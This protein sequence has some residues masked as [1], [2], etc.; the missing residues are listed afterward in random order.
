MSTRAAAAPPLPPAKADY[1]I[2][3][4]KVVRHMLRR[5]ALI[6]LLGAAIWFMNRSSAAGPGFALFCVLAVIGLGFVAAALFMRWS[7]QVGKVRV[8]DQILETLPWRGDEK[9]LDAGCGRGLFLIGAAKRLAKPAKATGVDIWSTED[10]AGNSAEAAMANARAEGV[11]D[12]V[13]IETG[14]LRK[15]PYGSSVFDTVVSSLAIHNLDEPD[16]REKAVREMWR[17]L[18]SGGHLAVFDVAHTA[19]YLNVLKPAG[20]E[21]LRESG[22]S[23]LWMIP[24][25]RWFIV[26]KPSV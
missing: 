14:D 3:A 25:T 18:K 12:R 19:D 13:K 5:G 21:L 11:A 10:L 20:A 23:M 24:A 17:V 7:S 16:D 1:G 9:V 6:I 8:R 26:R 22:F 2:D 4:P 15:L